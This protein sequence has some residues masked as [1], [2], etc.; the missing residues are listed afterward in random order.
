MRCKDLLC[1]SDII[2]IWYHIAILALSNNLAISCDPKSNKFG[3][4]YNQNTCYRS[5]IASHSLFSYQAEPNYAFDQAEPSYAFAPT[6]K[7]TRNRKK[8]RNPKAYNIN[9]QQDDRR[10]LVLSTL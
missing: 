7:Y 9:V 8:R 2:L 1:P 6:P 10:E 4:Q 5:A 3:R